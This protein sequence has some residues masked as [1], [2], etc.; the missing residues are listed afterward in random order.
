ML[1]E[2]STI[3]TYRK[4]KRDKENAPLSKAAHFLYL[5]YTVRSDFFMR[6]QS[7]REASGCGLFP[8]FVVLGIYFFL[9]FPEVA[10]R[11]EF[12]DKLGMTLVM[13]VAAEEI[14]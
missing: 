7:L 5:F 11:D 4:I 1:S 13:Q 9:Y 8:K 2:D 14:D 10:A 6:R 12:A 3:D